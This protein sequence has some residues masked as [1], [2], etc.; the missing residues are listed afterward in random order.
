LE[1]QA[2]LV[3]MEAFNP[4][5]HANQGGGEGSGVPSVS[6][7]I[8]SPNFLNSSITSVGG[9]SVKFYLRYSF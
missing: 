7:N 2:F 5:N 8:T 3:R 6:G 4:F 1:S 9:R